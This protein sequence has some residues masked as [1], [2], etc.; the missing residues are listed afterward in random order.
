MNPGVF[1]ALVALGASAGA[2]AAAGSP[3][4]VL[5]SSQKVPASVTVTIEA[6]QFAPSPLKI[7]AGTPVVF[8]N[9][10]AAPHT[11]TPDDGKSFQ[12]TGRIV[13][14]DRKTVVFEKPGTFNYHCEIHT[15]MHGKVVV[16]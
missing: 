4:A 10:D 9:K 8:V 16:R 7:P 6:F 2:P 15:T 1:L 14:G 11:A 12:G 5:A 3:P 13:S